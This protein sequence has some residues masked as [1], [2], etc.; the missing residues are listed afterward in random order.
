[1][2]PLARRDAPLPPDEELGAGSLV[3]LVGRFDH[4]ADVLLALLRELGQGGKLDEAF[5]WFGL[6]LRVRT[7]VAGWSTHVREHTIQLDKTVALLGHES[8]EVERIVRL[9]CRAYSA[10]EVPLLLPPAEKAVVDLFED[11]VE[12]VVGLGREL[13]AAYR[14]S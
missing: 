10:L 11:S 4:C 9:L 6:T 2:F 13:V 7:Y 8:G 12:E 14:T 3:T 5:D 1:L